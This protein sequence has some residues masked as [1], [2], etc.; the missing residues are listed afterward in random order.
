MG[1]RTGANRVKL[2][3][4]RQIV[5]GPHR[6]EVVKVV[7]IMGRDIVVELPHGKRGHRGQRTVAKRRE[8]WLRHSI[9]V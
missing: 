7:R 3:Q 2:G 8:Y 9:P 4:R 6:G 5:H 1:A